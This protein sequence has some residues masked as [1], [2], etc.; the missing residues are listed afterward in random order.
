[1]KGDFPFQGLDGLGG[2]FEGGRCDLARMFDTCFLA[3][4]ASSFGIFNRDFST[5]GM[6][7]DMGMAVGTKFNPFL[8]TSISSSFRTMSERL[9]TRFSC[10]G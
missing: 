2:K 1:M 5:D 8:R 10:K 4:V 7:P 9:T 6:I 3:V